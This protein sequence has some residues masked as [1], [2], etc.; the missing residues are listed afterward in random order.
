M[1]FMRLS[2]RTL[3][4]VSVVS[5][6]LWTHLNRELGVKPPELASLKAMYGRGRTLFDHQQLA[7]ETLGFRWLTDHQRRSFVWALR[8]EATRL[9]D[10]DQ[11]LNFAQRW[12]Y[13]RQFLIEHYRSLRTQIVAALHLF[14]SYTGASIAATVPRNL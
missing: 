6:S 8:D 11:L 5:A 7:R 13:N 4:E 10:K 3:N 14:E 1:G 2:G 12:L 9:S